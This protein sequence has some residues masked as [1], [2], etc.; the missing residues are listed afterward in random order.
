MAAKKIALASVIFLALILQAGFCA[1]NQALIVSVADQN[2]VPVA[3]AGVKITYQ[4]ANGITGNDGLAEGKT[5]EDGSY[6]VTIANTVPAGMEDR[7]IKVTASAYDWQGEAKTVQAED[8]SE[9]KTVQFTAPFTLGKMTLVVLQP[10]GM[11]APGASI[12]ITG[13][14]MKRTADALGKAVIYL[15][16][17]S[18]LSGFASYENDGDYFSTSAATTAD[19]GSRELVVK[20]PGKG[21]GAAASGGTMLTVKFIS[22]DGTALSGEKV[23]FSHGGA[24]VSAYTD[25]GGRVSIDVGM[26]REILASVKKNDY[27]YLFAFNVTA[28]GSPK[29]ETAMLAPLLKIDYFESVSDG[30][31]CYRLSAKASDPRLNKPI[32][33]K[34]ALVANGSEP[35]SEIRTAL[36]ENGMYTGRVCAGQ[37]ISVKVVAS[38]S[39]ET[40]EKTISLSPAG[41]PEPPPQVNVP[42]PAPPTVLPKPVETSPVEGL[43]AILVGIVMLVLIF[44]AAALMLGRQ[45]PQAAGGM[46]RYFTHTWGMMAEST[47]RPIVEYLRSI[48]RKKEPPPITSFGQQPPSGPMMPPG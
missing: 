31:G 39:Y 41:M 3:G 43:G 28:D 45:N 8:G 18:V 37:G 12:Y 27:N 35:A 20:F 29:N 5:G 21:T 16:E 23:V 46:A 25:A 32:S 19:D 13:S 24:D 1:W 30:S 9:A 40:A 11:P 48:F 22:T 34:M 44:G 47:V 10:N 33:V 36:D 15:P 26:D 14:E 4:K 6:S 17:G 38:N 2:G 7:R 42:P